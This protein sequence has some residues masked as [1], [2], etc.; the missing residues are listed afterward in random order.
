M[1]SLLDSPP[2]CLAFSNRDTT[3]FQ[4]PTPHSGPALLL[5]HWRTS[6]C[7]QHPRSERR[8]QNN[9]HQAT[10]FLSP[11]S[12]GPCAT[13]QFLQHLV[14]H[15][16]GSWGV[17]PSPSFLKGPSLLPRLQTVTFST[18][19]SQILQLHSPQV[20]PPSHLCLLHHSCTGPALSLP[21]ADSINRAQ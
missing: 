4:S 5:A 20:H 21:T 16:V 1:Q 2:A 17:A 15:L 8:G 11:E 14:Q 9:V 18:R 13:T 7:P 3:T 19:P 12:S 10:A 6:I